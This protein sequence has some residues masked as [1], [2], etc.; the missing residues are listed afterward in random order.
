ME[1]KKTPVEQQGRKITIIDKKTSFYCL[2]MQE[3]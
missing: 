3:Q 2:E 1:K